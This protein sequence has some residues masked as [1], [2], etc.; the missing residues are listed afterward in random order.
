MSWY[1]FLKAVFG[2]TARTVT[3]VDVEGQEHL[4]RRDPY[5]LVA[6]HQSILDPILVQS[7]LS[8]N[9]VFT[10]TKST[11]FHGAFFRWIMPRVHAI[12]VRRYRVD[13][14]AVRMVLRYL[15]K[16]RVVGIYPEGERSWDGSIQPMRR[17][18]IRVIL[19]AG[20]PVVPCGVSGSFDVWP[21]WSRRVRRRPI[22][23]RFGE[24]MEFGRHDDREERER[25]LEQTSARIRR[26]LAD[27]S[28]APLAG[29][30][31]SVES[32]RLVG[33][34][35]AAPDRGGPG[36]AQGGRGP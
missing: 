4:L 2:A 3:R 6:N 8:R 36:A 27:L 9:D 33:E 19:K 23:I 35:V 25:L 22:R 7:A 17:G 12:P 5:I 26:V 10:L 21:R 24:P 11:Q 16:G 30:P 13:P 18:S 29:E 20:V 14:Q 32:G 15:E 28:G 31:E 1:A 34:R